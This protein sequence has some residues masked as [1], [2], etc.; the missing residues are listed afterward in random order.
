MTILARYKEIFNNASK[1]ENTIGKGGN[2]QKG[3]HENWEN[4]DSDVK[5][6]LVNNKP[7]IKP[8]NLAVVISKNLEIKTP[9]PM[10]ADSVKFIATKMLTGKQ[11]TIWD[12]DINNGCSVS[13]NNISTGFYKITI[14]SYKNEQ[15]I[16]SKT[17][18]WVLYINK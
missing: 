5:T 4:I 11:T 13:F 12:R 6:V 14:I 17:I 1:P 3:S 16:A 15:K 7:L 9:I 10:N 8:F 18:T 2:Y